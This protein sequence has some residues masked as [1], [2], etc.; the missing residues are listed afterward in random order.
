ME[1]LGQ[2][3]RS[4]NVTKSDDKVEITVDLAIGV[5][6][7]EPIFEGKV[8]Y[9]FLPDSSVLVNVNGKKAERMDILPRIGLQLIMP[10]GFENYEYFGYGPKESYIDKKRYTYVDDFTTTVT[11]NFEHYVRPQENS[12]HYGCKWAK[13]TNE[14]GIGFICRAEDFDSFSSNAQ[15]FTPQMI[16]EA[17]HDYELEPM[18]ETVST[19]R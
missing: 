2:K 5:Y 8:T 11:E 17:K 19:I 13:V 9:T 12:S 15:H 7:F 6:T 14:S 18:K 1:K 3:C 10:E 4:L 16:R